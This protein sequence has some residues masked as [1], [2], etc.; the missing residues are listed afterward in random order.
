MLDGYYLHIGIDTFISMMPERVN[1]LDDFFDITDGFYWREENFRNSKVYRICSGEYARTVNCAYRTT[2]SHLVSSGL[3]VIVDEV[4][5]S[6]SEF[7]IWQQV[8]AEHKCCFVGVLCTDRVLTQ[9]ERERGDRKVG[10]ALEQNSRVHQDIKY[11]YT[12]DTSK[13]TAKECAE[14]IKE[15]IST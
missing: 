13:H 4:T 8:L 7:K 6:V 3:K 5:D 1:S 10:S 9:R 14:F 15:Y 11:D 2:I 12:V